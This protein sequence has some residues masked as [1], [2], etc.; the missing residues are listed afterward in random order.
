VLFF[1]VAPLTPADF[2]EA[3]LPAVVVL[4]IDF[5]GAFPPG[6]VALLAGAGL[7][8][9]AEC[10][11]AVVEALSARSVLTALTGVLAGAFAALADVTLAD[12]LLA[13]VAEEAVR[14]RSSVAVPAVDEAFAFFFTAGAAF[15]SLA[16]LEIAA[17]AALFGAAALLRA[18]L[19][20]RLTESVAAAFPPEAGLARPDCAFFAGS[21]AFVGA[22]A[23]DAILEGVFGPVFE[24]AFEAVFAPA[25]VCFAVAVL[26]RCA[27]LAPCDRDSKIVDQVPAE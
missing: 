21:A 18:V 10:A 8:A 20:T 1:G 14:L 4:E 7:V 12:V 5:A 15:W 27:T 9:F 22:A 23:L 13:D 25:G 11:F 2:A 19:V 6:A 16:G 24:G 3:A 17:A 26:L